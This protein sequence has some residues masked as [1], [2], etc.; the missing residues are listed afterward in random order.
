MFTTSTAPGRW[1]IDGISWDRFNEIMRTA[2]TEKE[3][4][5]FYGIAAKLHAYERV[6]LSPD[7][8]EIINNA[9]KHI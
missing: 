5:I 3:R 8:C 6:G 9:V 7:Q 1:V 4:S 2:A